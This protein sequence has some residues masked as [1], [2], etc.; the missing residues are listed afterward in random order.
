M[1]S[2]ELI[3]S[4]RKTVGIYIRSGA[5][6]VRAPLNMKK[7]EIDAIV[8]SKAKWITDNLARLIRLEEERESFSLD[9]GA[10]VTYR[11]KPY[12]IS[13]KDGNV[14]GFDGEY[15]FVPLALTGDQIKS[16]CADIYK[17]LAKAYITS[18]I[19][20]LSRQM[21]VLPTAV[22]VSSAKT[23]WGSCSSKGS[24]NFSWRLMMADDAVIDYVLVHELA[25]ITE[26]NHSSEF[27]AIVEGI[28]PDYRRRRAELAKLQERITTEGWDNI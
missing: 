9:Y 12:L 3:R 20:E 6:Q 13:G 8:S 22:K 7:G 27:W 14:A 21:N 15:F 26:M 19:A 1:I 23:R 11:G 24:L 28:L 4:K 25:H 2:Y 18:R 5:V 10:A 16:I 17:R